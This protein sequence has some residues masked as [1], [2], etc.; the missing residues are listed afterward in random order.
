MSKIINRTNEPPSL[1]GKTVVITGASSGVGRA[2]A[3][4]FARK[5]AKLILGARR[6]FT[7]DEVV[8]ECKQLGGTA[9]AVT[10]DVTDADA[11]K[12]L[13]AM[14]M[15]FGGEIDIWVNNAGVLAAGP[16]EETPVEVHDEVIRIN[17]MGY[18]HGAHAV[19]P[20]FKKQRKGILIN[21]IS[22]GGWFPTPYA[23]GYSASKFGLRGFSEA[24]RGEL[25]KWPDIH[26]CNLFPAFLDTPGIQHA[27]NYTGR[28]LK[29]APPVYDPQRVA[30]AVVF[31][32]QHPKQ[33][34]TIGGVATLLRLAH[35][36]LPTLTL[37]IT[38]RVIET[39]F[40]KADPMPA[41]SGNVFEP[42]D[43]GTSIHGGWNSPADEERR[44]KKIS[45]LLLISG[46]LAGVYLIKKL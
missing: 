45:T 7:L 2:I 19:I 30:R 21:N 4:G 36:L 13:A 31:L 18:I 25:H 38:A 9:M 11:V 24:L 46:F 26:V 44:K 39:Y 33:S 15:E 5:G 1:S 16:F 42:L 34:T 23:V 41:T 29:P 6:R 35:F 37:N 17:L 22:L 8:E 28:E 32:A 40:K 20:H 14:A 43:F 10:T 12:R 27:G 3:L